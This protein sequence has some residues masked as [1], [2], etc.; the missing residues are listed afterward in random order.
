MTIDEKI[1]FEK[2]GGLVPTVVQDYRTG[3]VLMLA[4]ANKQALETTLE[5]RKATFWSTSRKEIWTKGLTSGSYMDIKE[6][7]YD[8]DGDALIYKVD[9]KGGACHTKDEHEE[10]RRSCFFRKLL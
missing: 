5:L 1:N 3:E 10:S 4:Y 8:C 2:R 6:I 7:L 9:P